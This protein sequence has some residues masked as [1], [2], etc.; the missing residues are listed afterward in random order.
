[1]FLSGRTRS[2]LDAVATQIVA[3]GG[4]AHAAVIDT[5]DDVAVNEYVDG[6]VKQTGK[7]DIILDFAGPQAK[8]HGN[9]KMAVAGKKPLS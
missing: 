4:K 8:D 5:L 2:N 1:M 9:G 6:I 7:I 3:N